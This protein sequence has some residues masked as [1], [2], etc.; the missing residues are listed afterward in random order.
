MYEIFMGL[1]KIIAPFIPFITEEIYQN[2]KTKD[3][4]ES[5]H[6]CDYVELNKKHID[7]ELE[8]GM[9]K[10]RELVE[11]GRALDQRLE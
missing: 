11:V 1:S 4:P 3:M 2:L 7:E 5:I 9:K 6:L 8:N 10:I